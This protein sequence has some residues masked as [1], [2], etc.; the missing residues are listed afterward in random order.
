MAC[1]YIRCAA[2]R[3]M[4]RESTGTLI[5]AELPACGQQLLSRY[6]ESVQTV[7]LDPPFN[8][9]RRFDMKCAWAHRG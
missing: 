5:Q 3:Q 8:T 1:T 9:G 2:E 6:G 4:G 7:Y